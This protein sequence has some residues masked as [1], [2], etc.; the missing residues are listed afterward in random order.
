MW[1]LFYCMDKIISLNN[2]KVHD[3]YSK[4]IFTKKQF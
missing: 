1:I 3:T 4:I 2:L